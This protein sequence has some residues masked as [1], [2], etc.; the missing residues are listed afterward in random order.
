MVIGDLAV[1]CA[2]RYPKKDAFLFEGRRQTF[3][4]FNER[5]NKLSSSLLNL[6]LKPGSKVAVL[7]KNNP[8]MIEIC[9]AAAKTAM[10][11]VPLNFRLVPVELKFV[12]NDA[13]VDILF[14]GDAFKTEIE[15]IRG[16]ISVPHVIQMDG[17]YEPLVASGQAGE[18]AI[19]V[20]PGDTFAIFYTSGTTGGPKGVILSHD[21]FLSGVVNNVIA[22]KLGPSDVCLHV[23][24]FYHTMQKNMVL[25][26]FY[27]GGTN[28]IMNNFDGHEFWKSVERDGITHMTL[29]YTGL[30][31]ILDA[32][33]EGNYSIGTLKSY[34]VGGQTTPL[35]ILQRAVRLLGPD[36]VFVVY[37]LTEASPLLT[38]LPKE[39]VALAGVGL[40]RLGSVGKE[41]FSCHVRVVDHEG[42]DVKQGEMGEIIARGPNVMAGYWKRTEETTRTLEDGWLHTGDMATVDEDGYIYVVDRKKDLIISGGENISPHEI[43]DVLHLHPAIQECAAIGVP[44]DKW[45][46][47]VK[48]I[49]VLKKGTEVSEKGMIQFCAERLAR[50]KLPRSVDFVDALPKDPVGKIQKKILREQYWE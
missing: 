7:S 40:K 47:Q 5:V 34:A 18:P 31:M 44:D 13:E 42:N 17:E 45:G 43:E 2:R 22:Y 11:Y 37:G 15:T 21:N 35:P 9:F 29:V 23:Q 49:V 39:D 36:V 1:Q 25:C 14:V 32:L 24:P 30:V 20:E 41:L 12:I 8:E 27:V 28:V 16:E 26:Q 38:Y 50:Y 10:V 48:A 33:E 19:G 6:G 3:F 46:E 4:E